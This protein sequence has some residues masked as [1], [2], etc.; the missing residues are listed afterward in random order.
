MKEIV[1]VFCVI[2][3]ISQFSLYANSSSDSSSAV[4]LSNQQTQ[5][6]SQLCRVWGYLKY[7]H[8]KVSRGK[9]DWDK[10]L[11]DAIPMSIAAKDQ[12]SNEII[13]K[14]LL[15]TA[16]SVNPQK[17]KA[18]NIEE[19]VTLEPDYDWMHN[20]DPQLKV[21]LENMKNVSKGGYYQSFYPILGIPL[22]KK[23][24]IYEKLDSVD[25][26]HSLLSLFRCWNAVQYYYPYKT[27][28]DQDW[29]SVL[30]EMIPEFINATSRNEYDV[31][32]YHLASKI[33][34]NHVSVSYNKTPNYNLD[35]LPPFYQIPAEVKF[36][37]DQL[38]VVQLKS[39]GTVNPLKPGDVLLSV[40]GKSVDSVLK[41]MRSLSAYSNE[42]CFYNNH[43][44]LFNYSKDSV[45]PLT[46]LRENIKVKLDVP[47][48]KTSY[49]DLL[50]QQNSNSTRWVGKG[51]LYTHLNVFKKDSIAMLF[52]KMDSASTTIIDCRD[53]PDNNN[54]GLEVFTKLFDKPTCVARFSLV[55]K[56]VPG[57]FSYKKAVKRSFPVSD[58]IVSGKENPNYYKGRVII[59]TDVNTQSAAE[60]NTMALAQSPNAL[61]VGSHTAGANGNTPTIPLPYNRKIS[62][63]SLGVYYANGLTYQ[64]K[65]IQPDVE[66]YSTLEGIKAGMDEVLEKAIEVA[67][68]SKE[69][70]R[71]HQ[72]T[73]L[74]KLQPQTVKASIQ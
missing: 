9:Y 47:Y 41:A 29:N 7:H 64:R 32:V 68:W 69:E 24:N 20:L 44:S 19:V 31:A 74:K 45:I 53:Y 35:S 63:S 39:N 40:S 66:V 18:S 8:P 37:K 58:N 33:N 49:K 6:L 70:Y 13:I 60:T 34:D 72:G 5:N 62:L 56:Q 21:K 17:R 42:D 4:Q 50:L 2:L 11:M 16:G 25:R 73:G 65:G 54:N 51:I 28:L 3:S 43:R 14:G 46:I 30:E 1:A 36:V 55:D 71:S 27:L 26:E 48:S 52:A 15:E 23:E 10:V 59:L 12:A 61:V 67:G 38:F 22:Y 57:K